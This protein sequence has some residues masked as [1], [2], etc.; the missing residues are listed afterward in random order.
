MAL[1]LAACLLGTARYLPGG[2]GPQNITPSR[3]AY[4]SGLALIRQGKAKEAS[5]IF[6]QGLKLDP[7]NLLLLNALG[8]AYTLQGR[9]KEARQ[10][11]LAALNVDPA[12]SPAR[13]NLALSYF[14]A[15]EYASAKAEFERLAANPESRP[16][17]DLFLGMLAERDQQFEKAAGLLQ[18]AGRLL[19]QEPQGLIA[20]AH[21][22]FELGR[23]DEARIVLAALGELNRATSSNYFQAGRLCFQHGLY[24]ES[25]GFFEKANRLAPGLTDLDYYRAL[26]L[27]ELGRLPEALDILRV[28]TSRHPDA[29]VLNLLGHVAQKTGDTKLAIQS[30]YQ[31]AELAPEM[32]ENYLDYSELVLNSENYVLALKILDAGLAHIPHSYRLMV[33]KGAVLDKLT[34]RREADEVLRSAMKVQADNRIAMT[35]LAVVEAHDHRLNDAADTLQQAIT[36]YPADAYLRYYCGLVLVQLAE[37]QNMSPSAAE[38]AR[39]E[40]EEAIKLNPS[41]ADAYYQLAKTYVETDPAKATE[42]LEACLRRQPDHYA[43]EMQLGRLY[44]KMGRR[45]EGDQL[46]AKAIRDKQAE[47]DKEDTMQRIEEAKPSPDGASTSSDKEKLP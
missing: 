20:L 9:D 2:D 13:K 5:E 3:Q 12:F 32:E 4:E 18:A 16:I 17:A 21:C 30:F 6:E 19:P 11:F 34:R 45:L 39:H 41:Y 43:A 47:K 40:L 27:A 8:G 46:L 23:G 29:R 28:S 15:G 37:K 24:S 38:A 31:A 36:R 1:L 35:S 42:E 25:L 10:C 22:Y 33:E 7:A 26:T 14:H 44:Q